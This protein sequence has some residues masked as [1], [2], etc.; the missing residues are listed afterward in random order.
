[1]ASTWLVALLAGVGAG[2]AARAW[3]ARSAREDAA[4][5]LA[6]LTEALGVLAAELRSGRHLEAAVATTVESC[7][8]AGLG[9]SLARALRVPGVGGSAP[10]AGD[11]VA[12]ALDRVSAAVLLSQRTGCS[13]SAVVGAVEDDLRARGRQLQ[14]L[15]SAVAGPRASAG[16]LAAL[17]LLGLVMGTG[18]GADPWRVLTT[19]GTGQ[20]LLV[21]GVSLEW[22]GLAWSRRLVR[23]AVR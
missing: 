13:L 5:R 18:I 4:A 10:D 8:D 17:P 14:E 9:A 7:P 20:A 22:A 2:L 12:E 3:A 19:T 16:L 6:A 15:R 23:G 11:P 21:L 1:M